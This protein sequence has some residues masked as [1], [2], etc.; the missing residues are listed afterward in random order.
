MEKEN[1]ILCSFKKKKK[2]KKIL[3]HALTWINFK[4]TVLNKISQ[5]QKDKTMQFRSYEVSKVVKI[6]ETESRIGWGGQ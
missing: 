5:S 1:G 2:K 3:S 6:I 4:D